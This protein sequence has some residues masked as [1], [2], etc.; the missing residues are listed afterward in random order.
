MAFSDFPVNYY[1]RLIIISSIF[2]FSYFLSR[3]LLLKRDFKIFSYA[4]ISLL[5]LI[6]LISIPYILLDKLTI[7]ETKFVELIGNKLA[8]DDNDRILFLITNELNKI[9]EDKNVEDLLSNK[10]NASNLSFTFGLIVN[11]ARKILTHQL[12][13]LIRIII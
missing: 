2:L 1:Q 11:S 13:C 4:N 9:V 10:S 3:N 12:S 8:E 6:S 7:Q 5:V